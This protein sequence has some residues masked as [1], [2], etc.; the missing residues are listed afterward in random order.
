MTPQHRARCSKKRVKQPKYFIT[1]L[2]NGRYHAIW[3]EKKIIYDVVFNDRDEVERVEA[4]KNPYKHGKFPFVYV[5][6]DP[7]LA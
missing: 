7:S 6:Y 4:M 1:P 2:G 5:P 3:Q